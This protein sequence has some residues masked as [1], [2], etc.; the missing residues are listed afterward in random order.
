MLYKVRLKQKTEN[1]GE[2][3]ASTLFGAFVTAYSSYA[4]I[5]KDVIDDIVLSDL[6]IKNQLPTG[7]KNNNTS[8]NKVNGN[9]KMT[10][11]TRTLVTRDKD[12][13]N[14]VSVRQSKFNSNCEFYIS[15]ELLDKRD[16][17]KITGTML[18]LGIGAWR[19]AGKGQFELV[20]IE[21]YTLDTSKTHF[22]ALGS[23]IPND[24]D[25]DSIVDTGYEIRN[26]VASNGIRQPVTTLL[27]TGTTFSS[28]K[29]IVGKHVYDPKSKTYIHGKSIVI[30]V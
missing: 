12:S 10:S 14:V 1:I 3:K 9:S 26:A 16:L 28:Y 2:I 25:I 24:C 19:S 21:E 15:T 18:I 20:D 22:V 6:F 5:N 13:N 8:Y 29:G 17:E 11:V 27:K 23:F 30:G 4:D 7:I